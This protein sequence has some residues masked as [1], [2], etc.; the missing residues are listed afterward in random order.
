MQ[1]VRLRNAEY[2]ASL[3]PYRFAPGDVIEV[4]DEWAAQL[5]RRGIAR[6]AA[7]DAET[8]MDRRSAMKAELEASQAAVN[9]DQRASQRAALLAQLADL[10][11]AEARANEIAAPYGGHYGDTIGREDLGGAADDDAGRPKAGYQ[12][13]GR[14]A[15]TATADE[16]GAD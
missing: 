3:P 1:K 5:V 6:M 9:A 15:A 11:V 7:A 16:H 8:V 13:R 10:D 2:M 14:P 4:D 12:R